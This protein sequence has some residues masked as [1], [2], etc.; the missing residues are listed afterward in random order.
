MRQSSP[1]RSGRRSRRRNSSALAAGRRGL[2]RAPP[3]TSGGTRFP[4]EEQA[5]A[6]LAGGVDLLIIETVFDLL[7]AKAA[8]NACT[9]AMVTAGRRV[10]LQVQVT[11]ELTGRMLPGTEIGAALTALEAMRPDV[12]GLNCATGPAEMG[13]AVRHLG[14]HSRL[15]VAVQPNAGLPI[16]GRRGHALRPH[17]DAV[18]RPPRAVRDRARGDRDRRVLRDHPDHLAAVV[19]RCRDLTRHRQPDHEPS[20]ASIYSAVPFRQD[21]SFL[22]VGERTNANGSKQ[23]REAMLAGDWDTTVP[24]PATR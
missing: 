22:V 17:P 5:T 6:L 7:Q 14:Q 15:P 9:R 8:M 13:E 4:Y 3:K 24:W 16:G 19:E 20:A 23:F 10:P 2:Q 1:A 11:I 12:I 21:T 18:G